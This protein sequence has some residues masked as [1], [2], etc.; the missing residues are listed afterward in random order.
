[1]DPFLNCCSRGTRAGNILLLLYCMEV[2]LIAVTQR[3]AQLPLLF[4]GTGFVRDHDH[5]TAA[6]L[7]PVVARAIF[8]FFLLGT[9]RA[10]GQSWKCSGKTNMPY[11]QLLFLCVIQSYF[12]ASHDVFYQ[13]CL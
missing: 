13:Q 4:N 7:F 12:N 5:P 9:T 8:S 10:V 2:N 1:M 11:K 6:L 3:A